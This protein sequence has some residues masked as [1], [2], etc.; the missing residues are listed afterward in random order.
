MHFWTD[1]GYW[2]VVL[3][4]LVEVIP[5]ELV[6]AYGGYLVATGQCTFW[7]M[8]FWAT[9][10]GVVAQLMLYVLGRV[11]G[12]QLCMRY[13]AWL[14]LTPRR[15]EQMEQW[16]DRYGVG[17]VLI[18][19]LIPIMRHAIS[20]PAGIARMPV[21]L[22]VLLTTLAVLPWTMGFVWLG[23]RLGVQWYFVEELVSPYVPWFI[24]GVVVVFIGWWWMKKRYAQQKRYKKIV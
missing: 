14:L 24:F 8:V 2:G 23:T 7:G 12:R 10:S 11:G 13:G 18:A 15:M 6:L 1:L 9:V 4:L 16:F 22:F 5:S 3:A 21:G 20:V 17:V 19:R